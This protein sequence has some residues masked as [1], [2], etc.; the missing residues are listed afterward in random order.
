MG[1]GS[2]LYIPSGGS[3][4]SVQR[5][6]RAKEDPVWHVKQTCYASSK[7]ASHTQPEGP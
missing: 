1:S 4:E 6:I 3:G 7:S 5:S 2:V